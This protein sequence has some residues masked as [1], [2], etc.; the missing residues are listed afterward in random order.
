MSKKVLIVY[1]T[2][3]M[4]HVTAAKATLQAFEQFHPDVEV[5]NIDI[6]D[7]AHP[8]YKKFF[9][10]GYNWVSSK[11]PGLWGWLYRKF[12][13]KSSQWLPNLISR[14]AI[15]PRFIPFIEEFKPD[16]II[17]THPL[18]MVLI[19]YSKRKHLMDIYSSMVV[20]DFGCHSFWVD[21]QVNYYFG[22]VDNVAKCLYNYGVE[23]GKV[24]VT[25][26]PIELKFSKDYDSKTIREN[27]GLSADLPTVLIVGGQFT[28]EALL[29]IINGVKEKN[30]GKVQFIVVAGRDKDLKKALDESDLQKDSGVKVFGFVDNMHELMSASDLIFSKAGGLTTSECMALGLPMVI[31]KVIPGQ[32]EDNVEY[33]VSKNAAVKAADFQDI[34]TKVNELLADPAKLSEMQ[35]NAK[36]IGRP[37][38]AKDLTDFVYRKISQ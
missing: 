30:Q 9:V 32:E 18:P 12:N 22:A 16:F 29:Q 36:K 37:N 13:N 20:T 10:D 28:Y 35:Q 11:K 27:I 6:I 23:E 25:G 26:I 19:S 21:S 33:L 38:S 5:K 34:V 14:W 15:S 17:S 31:N 24:V 2:G 7:F 4:G 8:L 1:A 3:G